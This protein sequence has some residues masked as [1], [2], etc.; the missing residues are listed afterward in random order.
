MFQ[1][2]GLG[3]MFGEAEHFLSD[4]LPPVPHAINRYTQESARLYGVLNKRL[5]D[6][7]CLAGEYSI[8]EI[9]IYPWVARHARQRIDLAAYPAVRRWFEKVGSRPAI[10]RGMAVPE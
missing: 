3:P 4:A 7:E 6:R 5:S 1:M 8:A 2:G 9:A 10:Q